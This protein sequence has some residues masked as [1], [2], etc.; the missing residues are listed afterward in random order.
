MTVGKQ[1]GLDAYVTGSGNGWVQLQYMD[2]DKNGDFID[3]EVVPSE[4]AKR[5]KFYYKTNIFYFVRNSF[6]TFFFF[7]CLSFKKH[8]F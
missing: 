1:R 4:C 6:L 2:G 3:Q 5:S 8:F 7:V